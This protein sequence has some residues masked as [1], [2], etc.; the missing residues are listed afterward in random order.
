MQ[1]KEMLWGNYK[2]LKET[3]R[4]YSSMN[5]SSDIWAISSNPLTDFIN[6]A[7]LIDGKTLKL[8]DLVIKNTNLTHL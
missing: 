5:P 4:H 3:Y 8:S 1:V 6:S 7:E 2:S